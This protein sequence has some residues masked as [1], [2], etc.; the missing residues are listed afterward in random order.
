[1]GVQE[2]EDICLGDTRS[3]PDRTSCTGTRSSLRPSRVP[4]L[5]C[6]FPGLRSGWRWH[7]GRQDLREQGDGQGREGP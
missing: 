2:G 6:P 5:D 7:L 3:D 4:M 1:M